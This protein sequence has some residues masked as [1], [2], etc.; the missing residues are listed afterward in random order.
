MPRDPFYNT[1]TWKHLRKVK[2]ISDPLCEVCK[3]EGRLK[4]ASDVDHVRSI[5]TGGHRTAMSNLQ[6]LCHECHSRKTF[7]VE[8]LGR[9][10]VPIK[11]VDPKTGRPY[12]PE[13]WWNK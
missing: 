3:A 13:H 9:S 4:A 12:D 7:Y 2:L 8:R 10:R 1:K 6:S 5:N 11:G